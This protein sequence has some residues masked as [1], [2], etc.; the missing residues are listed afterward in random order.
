LLRFNHQKIAPQKMSKELASAR[1]R[2]KINCSGDNDEIK[3]SNQ[4]TYNFPSLLLRDPVCGG[5]CV[6]LGAYTRVYGWL[7][8][9]LLA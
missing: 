3:A 7:I 2:R 9:P 5:I 6:D 8:D 1:F 4:T